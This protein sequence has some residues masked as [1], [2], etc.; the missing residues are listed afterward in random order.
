MSSDFGKSW[1]VDN[2][3]LNMKIFDLIFTEDNSVLVNGVIDNIRGVFLSRDY[4]LFELLTGASD[5][6]K[7]LK[8]V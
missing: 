4:K 8:T 1:K 5:G 7:Y 3:F 6:I 2:R